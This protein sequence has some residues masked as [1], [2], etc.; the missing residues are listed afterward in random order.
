M[1]LRKINIEE[2]KLS[3]IRKQTKLRNFFCKMSFIIALV[4]FRVYL[5]QYLGNVVFY[6]VH[7]QGGLF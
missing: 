7:M 4:G 1:S 3:N 6:L 5:N 2:S